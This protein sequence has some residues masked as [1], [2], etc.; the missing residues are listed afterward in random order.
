MVALGTLEEAAFLASP[1]ERGRIGREREGGGGWRK[2]GSGEGREGERS[3]ARPCGA[4]ALFV[5]KGA[6]SP[7]APASCVT[8]KGVGWGEEVIYCSPT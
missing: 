6:L 2:R 7:P 5:C 8:G 3:I 1:G 4:A